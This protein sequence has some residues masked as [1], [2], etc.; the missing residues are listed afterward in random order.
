MRVR[1]G[2]DLPSWEI[3]R[4]YGARR[5]IPVDEVAGLLRFRQRADVGILPLDR[6]DAVSYGRAIHV[7]LAIG[8]AEMALQY[9]L[10]KALEDGT[11][12]KV[13]CDGE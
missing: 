4:A 2:C 12:V 1:W 7:R 8:N 9:R 11:P 13:E 5:E 6:S 10:G 3:A